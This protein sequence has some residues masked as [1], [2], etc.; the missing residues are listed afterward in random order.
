MKNFLTDAPKLLPADLP[1]DIELDD[2]DRVLLHEI[3]DCWEEFL[4][5]NPTVLQTGAQG[6]R[7]VELEKELEELRLAKENVASELNRQLQ[8]FSKSKDQLEA[9]FKKAMA[10]E[11]SNQQ[12][13]YNEWNKQTENVEVAN[14]MFN[15]ILP[16]EHFFQNLDKAAEAVDQDGGGNDGSNTIAA[17]QPSENSLISTGHN[18]KGSSSTSKV[19]KPS[20][21]S[22][23]LVEKSSAD[24][25]R[26]IPSQDFQLRAYRVDN[27]LLDAEVKMVQKEIDQ[28]E[29]KAE[30]MEVIGKFMIEMGIWGLMTHQQYPNPP[31]NAASTYAGGRSVGTKSRSTG[32][33]VQP[34]LTTSRP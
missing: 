15:Q 22:S 16:W 11:A 9:N 24:M 26:V 34:V 3:E 4:T 21:R 6:A 1:A 25:I 29:K 20:T 2:A 10:I 13:S 30:Y 14:H 19:M 31:S 33:P 27:A 17:D 5:A 8:F 32:P 7:I 28:Q 23:L 18:S 12:K